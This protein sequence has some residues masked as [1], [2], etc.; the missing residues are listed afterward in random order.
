METHSVIGI[1]VIL[2]VG[3]V[4]AALHRIACRISHKACVGIVRSN[5]EA[6]RG[7]V[8]D[9]LGHREIRRGVS[10]A[11]VFVIVH[12]PEVDGDRRSPVPAVVPVGA[13]EA[14]LRV[15]DA[16]PQG[17]GV[18]LDYR[19][20]LGSVGLP[21]VVAFVVVIIQVRDISSLAYKELVARRRVLL[22]ELIGGSVAHE[23]RCLP[24][25]C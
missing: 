18:L 1:I 25:R 22:A 17:D 4:M 15:A 5:C 16:F 3:T 2:L 13:E 10:V 7:R 8:I 24:I 12:I 20:R 23:Y 14:C 6:D 9:A 11:V 19:E 21:A